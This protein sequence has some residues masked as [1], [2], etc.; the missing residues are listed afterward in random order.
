MEIIKTACELCAWACGMDVYVENGKV[1]RVK[2]SK[3]NPLNRGRLCPKGSA[4]VDYLYS[5]DRILHP[6]KRDGEEWV[7]ISWEEAI[8]VIAEKLKKVKEEFSPK[9]FAAI[10]GMPILLGGSSTVGFIRR[11]MDV[12]GSPNCFSP[13]SMCYRHEIIGYILTTGKFS[14]ADP[15]NAKC[16][17]VWAH[18]PHAS[19]PP[20]AWMIEHAKKKGARI[21]VIDPRKTR[22]AEMADIHARIRPGSD[23]ALAIG[24]MKVIVEKDL[25]DKEFVENYC[26]GF[27][28][29]KEHLKNY[30]L[31]EISE[32]TWVDLET[33]EE[34]ARSIATIKPSCIVQG[35]NAL[36][37]VPTGVQN[38]R[39]VAMLHALTGNIDVKGGFV[40]ASRVHTNSL[41]LQEMLDSIPLGIKEHPLFYQVW[42]THLGEGQGMYLY[43]A[44][45]EEKPYPIKALFIAGSNPLL[46]WP[47][48][49]KLKRAL[50]KVEFLVVMDLFMTETAKMADIFL[51]AATFLERTEL[52]DYYSVIFGIPYM[53]L[54]KKVIEPLGESKS[55]VEFWLMLAKQMGYDKYF[56]WNTPEE[57]LDYVLE[58]TG[59]TVKDLMEKYPAGLWMGEVRYG[60]YIKRGFKT[61]SKKVELYSDTLKKLGYDPVPDHKEPTESIFSD[62]SKDFPLILTTGARVINYTHSQLRNVEKLRKLNPDPFVE[63]HPATAAQYGIKDGEMVVVKTE[64]G[65]IEIKAKITEGILPGVINIP[66]GW[67]NA[68]VNV[69]TSEKPGDPIS[70]CPELKALLAKKE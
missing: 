62:K 4:A 21:I 35:V 38:A 57:M 66:H 5:K 41:R 46:T 24:L 56:P 48:S 70:G 33:I 49:G 13:E 3:E 12:Y 36:D 53:V 69:L 65:E 59:L 10:I 9:S 40:R 51:P 6:M 27:D 25:Y 17:V 22:V 2:G 14:V 34:I 61:P 39:A 64:R 16:I 45:L 8:D 68:N 58:P 43:D 7:R 29:L 47:N 67:S 32:T 37:Q 54:R 11:F 28:S 60:E 19:K 18:N 42:G 44:I 63:I 31:E 55:D 26:H 30:S 1:I 50:E 15:E 23:T 52:C 20:L